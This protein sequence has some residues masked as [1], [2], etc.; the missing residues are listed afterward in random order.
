MRPPSG[1]LSTLI[2]GLSRDLLSPLA[3]GCTV[4][5]RGARFTPARTLAV[6]SRTA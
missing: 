1:A 6:T 3:L 5:S 4:A 2:A